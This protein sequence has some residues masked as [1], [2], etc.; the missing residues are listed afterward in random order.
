MAAFSGEEVVFK[1]STL[2]D[3]E[4]RFFAFN[5]FL[6][7][8][9]AEDVKGEPT[10]NQ[11]HKTLAKNLTGVPVLHYTAFDKAAFH[12][13]CEK[14]NLRGIDAY[15]L[16]IAK[17]V[18]RTWEDVAYRGYGLSIMA[19]RLGIEYKEHDALEDAI[20]AGKV[21]LAAAQEAGIDTLE[22]WFDRIKKPLSAGQSH[23][24]KLDGNLEGEY[25][26]ESLVF[27][28]ELSI[29]RRQAADLAARAG[30]S[31]QQGVNKHTTVLCVGA[32]D[33]KRLADYEKSSKQRKAEELNR[34]KGLHIRIIGEEDLFRM[35][36]DT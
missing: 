29:P 11:L 6:H 32:Q 10:F 16:D 17:V 13:A 35:I 1:Y 24:I 22:G 30:F 14:Y 25:Y 26:G 21:F 18:R 27:T 31:V 3:P 4:D 23:T 19:D 28:G 33:L 7:G 5:T 8:I 15:W 20:A 36:E 34:K 9:T 12:R 2:V